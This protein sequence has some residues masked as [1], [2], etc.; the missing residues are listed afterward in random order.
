MSTFAEL[1]ASNIMMTRP[2]ARELALHLIYGHAFTG[3]APE[4]LIAQR[5]EDSYRMGLAAEIPLYA[6]LP[7][8]VQRSYV[9]TVVA[10]VVERED[11]LNAQI[12]RYSIGW[13][14]QRI[15]R[16][17]RAVMQLAIF[18]ILYMQDIPVNASVSEAVR[19]AKAYDGNDTGA[20]V[21]GILGTFVR[22]L[23]PQVQSV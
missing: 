1:S 20:F 3:E 7:D 23:P 15:S 2:E 13:D 16:I 22:A 11:E 14:V 12:R 21:N 9:D 18:E 19:L 17:A 6:A 10:G 8:D 4:S 5:L